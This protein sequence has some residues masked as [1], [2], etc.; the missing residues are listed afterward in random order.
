MDLIEEFREVDLELY[1]KQRGLC[2][3]L[4][5]SK[6]QNFRRA[7]FHNNLRP[8]NPEKIYRSQKIILTNS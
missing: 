5:E 8:R 7:K 1:V 2:Q 4:F 6:K 3:D